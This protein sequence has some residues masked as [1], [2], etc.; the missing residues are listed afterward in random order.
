MPFE[1][2]GA[3]L[4][5]ASAASG[6]SRSARHYRKR[7][8]RAADDLWQTF[9][10]TGEGDGISQYYD[11]YVE[12]GLEA[13][14]RKFQLL[15]GDDY[16]L[17]RESPGYQFQMDE[18]E[19]AISRNALAKGRYGGAR[20]KALIEFAGGLADQDFQNAIDNLDITTAQGMNALS[21]RESLRQA[22]KEN[23]AGMKAAGYAGAAMGG[24]R[25][26][27]LKGQAISAG[28]QGLGSIGGA[29]VSGMGSTPNV[30]SS[31]GSMSPSSPYSSNIL[32]SM[33]G[34]NLTDQPN[35]GN[36]LTRQISL[37]R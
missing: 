8:S 1:A 36:A 33:K 23:Q 34:R 28:V 35:W 27:D 16:S 37:N 6:S 19:K 14:E 20:S 21:D 3:A 24:F 22:Y 7:M 31:G 26:A 12:R 15:T 4:G 30:L 29:I 17:Y 13:F 32:S 25:V 2:I 9:T 11:P 10:G 5:A 18:G